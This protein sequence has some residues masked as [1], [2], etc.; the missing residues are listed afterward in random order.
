MKSSA[1]GKG[2][3]VG[4][5]DPIRAAQRSKLNGFSC[6]CC[7]LLWQTEQ[8]RE[9]VDSA[10]GPQRHPQAASRALC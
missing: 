6:P 7:I 10:R 5:V 3:G 8:R 4:Q 2:S 1:G 9:Y